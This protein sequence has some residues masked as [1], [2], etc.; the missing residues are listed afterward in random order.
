MKEEPP[1]Q[2]THSVHFCGQKQALAGAG[3]CQSHVA[4]TSLLPS[5]AIFLL[6]SLPLSSGLCWTV[7]P[8][9]MV[10]GE[11]NPSV[12][13]GDTSFALALPQAR[14]SDSVEGGLP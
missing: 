5:S 2:H 6:L 12:S 9:P 11:R 13:L 10:T 3:R 1:S 14:Q 7:P 8:R 4:L